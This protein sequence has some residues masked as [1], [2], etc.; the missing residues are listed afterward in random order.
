MLPRRDDNKANQEFSDTFCCA[1]RSIAPS[2]P[3]S[4]PCLC[5]VTHRPIYSVTSISMG[6][7]PA[8]LPF[9][10]QVRSTGKTIRHI[11]RRI[12]LEQWGTSSARDGKV[13][14]DPMIVGVPMP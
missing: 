4:W 3:R 6:I 1:W 8:S 14:V 7:R 10:I 2:L 5:T 11:P 12:P 13:G 9:A